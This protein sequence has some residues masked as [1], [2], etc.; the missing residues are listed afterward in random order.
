MFCLVPGK[1]K[2]LGGERLETVPLIVSHGFAKTVTDGQ[3]RF[4]HGQV[5]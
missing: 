2:F 3:I 5:G 4:E 1:V